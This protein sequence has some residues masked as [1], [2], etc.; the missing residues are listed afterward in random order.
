MCLWKKEIAIGVAVAM[1]IE[2]GEVPCKREKKSKWW[3]HWLIAGDA[4]SR[5]VLLEELRQNEAKDF[6]Y[7]VRMDKEKFNIILNLIQ[8]YIWGGGEYCNAGG[9]ICRRTLDS[10]TWISSWQK[11]YGDVK[12]CCALLF[13]A[14]ISEYNVSFLDFV[15]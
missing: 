6:L 10:Y 11:S 9:R 4:F 14:M 13:P 15:L 7:Y 3:R 5:V 2:G 8:L 1:W 12:F